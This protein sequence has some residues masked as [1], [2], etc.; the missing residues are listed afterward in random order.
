MAMRE[1][2]IG[3][4]DIWIRGDEDMTMNMGMVGITSISEE[5]IVPSPRRGR[6]GKGILVS[7][8]PTTDPAILW[9]VGEAAHTL[10]LEAT[11]IACGTRIAPTRPSLSSQRPNTSDTMSDRP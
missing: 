3:E 6:H 2:G 5:D 10:V 11:S 7:Q 1:K 4:K 8:H 9:I